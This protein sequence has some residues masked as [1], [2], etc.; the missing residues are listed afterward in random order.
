MQTIKQ[1]NLKK[2]ILSAMLAVLMILMSLPTSLLAYADD[3]DPNVITN[4]RIEFRDSN[5]NEID[6]VTSGEQFYLNLSISGN[7]VNHGAAQT[8]YRVDITD[9]NLLLPNFAGKG[10]VDG[11]VYKGF[12]VHIN[13]DE[14]YL[15][16][17]VA[18]G[19]TKVVQ[20]NAKLK[21]GTTPDG[22]KVPVKIVQGS[23]SLTKSITAKSSSAW[24]QNKTENKTHI[25]AEELANGTNLEY[26]LSASPLNANKKTGAWWAESLEFED[27][28]TF[29][30]NLDIDKD[31]IA[32]AIE[33]S[34]AKVSSWTGNTAN[35]TYTINSTN[36]E[37]EM[38][39]QQIK[40]NI[41]INS[42]TITD[43]K[44]DGAE[45]SNKLSVYAKRIGETDYTYKIG[46][47]TVAA[48][49][50]KSSPEISV[51]KSVDKQNIVQNSD[52]TVTYTI[53][54]SNDGSKKDTVH[55]KDIL[56]AGAVVEGNIK[57]TSN[58]GNTV[59]I[60]NIESADFDV[61]AGEV[62]VIKYN[63]KLDTS[64]DGIQ[65]NT[66]TVTGME[67]TTPKKSSVD[68]TIEP[69]KKSIEVLKSANKNIY[70]EGTKTEIKY[71]ISVRNTGNVD[72]KNLNLKDEI[73]SAN[74]AYITKDL[75]AAA[76]DLKTGE[77]KQFTYTANVS[78]HATG[79]IDNKATV[80]GDGVIGEGTFTVNSRKPSCTLNS[81][82]DS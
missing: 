78:D 75:S 70:T 42:T 81:F 53:I 68:V 22:S 50:E 31:E 15:T 10:F 60:A 9:R 64:N 36:K 13:G 33:K 59:S 16:F 77:V 71:T 20:L 34:G 39:A 45:I 37:A 25:T 19:E 23:K 1:S 38:P 8:T 79:A 48:D 80:T 49:L 47:N 82:K 63:A 5:Y 61:N 54:V 29:D 26:V 62:I 57:A 11:A 24:T 66:V 18:N 76:F 43:V 44:T 65:K 51:E 4:A 7:N 2:R 55:L 35:I 32:K 69:E 17:T 73:T 72:L 58:K 14:R 40:I 12:T 21:N 74:N 52:G 6:E 41:P 56:P 3:I 27:T 30:D 46:E 28:L 67:D